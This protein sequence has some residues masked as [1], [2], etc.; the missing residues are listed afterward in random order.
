MQLNGGRVEQESG[1]E[2]RGGVAALSTSGSLSA[3]VATEV[4]SRLS[5]RMGAIIFQG[6]WHLIIPMQ[7]L[8]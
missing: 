7:T 3:E 4:E 8:V 5:L 2:G 1:G 6:L